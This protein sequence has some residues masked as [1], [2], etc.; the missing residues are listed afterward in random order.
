MSILKADFV[1]LRDVHPF[2]N[3]PGGKRQLLSELDKLIPSQF[4]SYREPFLGGGPLFFHLVSSGR[5]F[6]AYLQLI[7]NIHGSR[8]FKAYTAQLCV[9]SLKTADTLR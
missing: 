1:D 5:R 3:W 7:S 9:T 2:V 8:S 6:I 4:N